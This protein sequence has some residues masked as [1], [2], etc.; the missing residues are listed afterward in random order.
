MFRCQEAV[1]VN[2]TETRPNFSRCSPLRSVGTPCLGILVSRNHCRGEPHCL[3]LQTPRCSRIPGQLSPFTANHF[4]TVSTAKP[5]SGVSLENEVFLSLRESPAFQDPAQGGIQEAGKGTKEI[6]AKSQPAGVLSSGSDTCGFV[7]RRESEGESGRTRKAG[8]GLPTRHPPAISLS[9]RTRGLNRA[10][11]NSKSM[12]DCALAKQTQF[13]NLGRLSL[14]FHL[15]R[16]R[17]H[18]PSVSR[19]QACGFRLRRPFFPTTFFGRAKKVVTQG[20]QIPH[21]KRTGS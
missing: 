15:A 1:K 7:L 16:P 6:F 4:R 21:S 11:W 9:Q 2:P 20:S 17:F 13:W 8:I 18:A 14:S 12:A 3:V 10:W 19:N 5:V